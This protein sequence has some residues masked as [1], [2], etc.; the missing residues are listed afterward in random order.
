MEA[1]EEH[2]DTH[3]FS[4][5]QGRRGWVAGWRSSWFL[6]WPAGRVHDRS[7]GWLCS[8]A[9]LPRPTL[10]ALMRRHMRGAH[11]PDH[12]SSPASTHLHPLQGR[13]PARAA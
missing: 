1:F 12:T 8:A 4:R 11:H 2:R 3:L 10:H 5:R 13:H 9:A 6:S 7:A